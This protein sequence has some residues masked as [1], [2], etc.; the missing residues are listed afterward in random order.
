MCY[1][2]A[3]HGPGWFPTFILDKLP[4]GIYGDQITQAVCQEAQMYYFLQV[5]SFE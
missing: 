3:I 2:K 1:L 4:A 5:K